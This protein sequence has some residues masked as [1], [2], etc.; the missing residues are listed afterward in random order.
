M[1]REDAAGASA[2]EARSSV[3]ADHEDRGTLK[4][5]SGISRFLLACTAATLLS[6]LLLPALPMQSLLAAEPGTR[7]WVARYNPK[8]DGY[9]DATAVS[10]DGQMLF[11]TGRVLRWMA[12]TIQTSSRSPTAP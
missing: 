7:L 8:I 2:P 10:S 5:K 12:F 4:H 11:V 1:N 3:H 9:V 6:A